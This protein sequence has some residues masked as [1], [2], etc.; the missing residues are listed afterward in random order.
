MRS[1]S[2]CA[3]ARHALATRTSS[4]MQSFLMAPMRLDL[5]I[6]I[7]RSILVSHVDGFSETD[8]DRAPSNF[9]VHFACS[10][11][12]QSIRV[13]HADQFYRSANRD[14]AK[15]FSFDTKEHFP[16]VSRPLDKVE[17][18]G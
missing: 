18:P 4:T 6:N 17:R 11:Q 15:Q 13:F 5:E 2:T 9:P 3:G 1:S 16:P 14:D 10:F 8:A 12:R 7:P